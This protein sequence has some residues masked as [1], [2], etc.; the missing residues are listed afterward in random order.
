METDNMIFRHFTDENSGH[1]SYLIASCVSR[2][3]AIVNPTDGNFEECLSTIA[4][5][6]L[7]L[8]Y[9][10]ETTYD[11]ARAAAA[12]RLCERS[13]ALR[14]APRVVSTDHY[15]GM[16]SVD[17]HA[18][19]GTGIALGDLHIEVVTTPRDEESDVTYQLGPYKFVGDFVLIGHHES[20][21][22]PED[23]Q[24]EFGQPDEAI[25]VADI[26]SHAAP[27]RSYRTTR[28]GVS[29]KR[30]IMEDLHTSIAESRFTP[31]EER[32]VLT[33]LRFLEDNQ[34][35][36]PSASQLSALL[37]NVDRTAVHVLVHNIRWKQID[38]KRLPL[39]LDGQT[40][41]WLKG[42]QTE[43]EFTAH[44][45]EF[46]RA[47]LDLVERNEGPPSGPDIADA[48]GGRSVQWVRKRAHTIRRKQG[49]FNQPLLILIRKSPDQ[50]TT[51]TFRAAPSVEYELRYRA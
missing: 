22:R 14:V 27:I 28:E 34:L 21:V 10:L 41:K 6:N 24:A 42:L 32:V 43:P 50:R 20:T 12:R 51:Q 11:E 5:L 17:I 48:L 26:S 7:R 30:L 44:E 29:I 45:Q 16:G 9:T 39:V 38:L 37:D 2:Q 1:H 25:C 3:A 19:I 15:A 40:S 36:H 8:E 23:R 33:Y 13:G 47:Y 31:K 46:L 4:E 35:E 18:K 49:D